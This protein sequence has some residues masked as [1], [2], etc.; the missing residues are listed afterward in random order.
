[1]R[2][3]GYPTQENGYPF[4]YIHPHG[5]L[6]CPQCVNDD[7]ASD[8]HGTPP[9]KPEIHWEGAPI[10]CDGCGCEIESAY[11]DPEAD[12]HEDDQ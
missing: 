1:V 5:S 11:G 2:I 8:P 12:E 9:M 10:D 6:L 3:P 7:V 4:F